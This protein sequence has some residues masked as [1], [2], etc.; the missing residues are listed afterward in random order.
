M[1]SDEA[2]GQLVHGGMS[3]EPS[4]EASG[5]AQHEA[6][7]RRIGEGE[8]VVEDGGQKSQDNSVVSPNAFPEDK[9]PAV[10]DAGLSAVPRSRRVVS[11]LPHNGVN[12]GSQDD[13]YC[14][15]RCSLELVTEKWLHPL[16]GPMRI[17]PQLELKILRKRA[18]CR[19]ETR[20]P[21]L[22]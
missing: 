21:R 4:S 5:L 8:A 12:Y 15:L 16:A 9:D 18:L 20:Q 7:S 22:S 13:V 2:G 14:W 3:A 11:I 1:F 17:S 19:L 10:P 6:T